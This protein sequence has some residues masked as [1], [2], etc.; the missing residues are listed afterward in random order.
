MTVKPV[1]IVTEVPRR[2]G[3]PPDLRSVA[4]LPALDGVAELDHDSARSDLAA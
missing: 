1:R 4:V 2:P 3:Q